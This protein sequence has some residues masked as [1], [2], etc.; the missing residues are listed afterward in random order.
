[1]IQRLRHL[2]PIHPHWESPANT[3]HQYGEKFMSPE[4]SSVTWTL[5]QSLGWETQVKWK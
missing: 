2:R 4:L 3:L 1:M 5:Q